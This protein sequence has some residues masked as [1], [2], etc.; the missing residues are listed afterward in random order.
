MAGPPVVGGPR[1]RAPRSAMRSMTAVVTPGWSPTSTSTSLRATRAPRARSA[2]TRTALPL[3]STHSTTSIP[4]CHAARE[5]SRARAPS[6]DHDTRQTPA[7]AAAAASTTCSTSGRPSSSASSLGS[8]PNRDPAP[9]ARMTAGSSARPDR[10]L[11]RPPAQHPRE[12]ALVVGGGVQVAERVVPSA[13]C[14]AAAAIRSASSGW[15][16]SASSTARRPQRR[17]AHVRQP[18]AD[19]LARRRRRASTSAE[20]ATIAQSSARRLN[21]W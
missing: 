5:T 21:F 13:A 15:P 9:A 14:S 17:R 8:S 18:D 3:Q 11:Q 2:A 19:V 10:L 7:R 4:G 12:V 16:R 1:A 6:D 20:T